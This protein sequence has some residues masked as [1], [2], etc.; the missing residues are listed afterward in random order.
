MILQH[1]GL[2]LHTMLIDVATKNLAMSVPRF[3]LF[4][5]ELRDMGYLL[6]HAKP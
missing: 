1:T 3:M 2:L 6:L 4:T 5:V